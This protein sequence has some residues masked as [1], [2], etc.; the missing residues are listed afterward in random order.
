MSIENVAVVRRGYEALAGGDFGG[1][2]GLLDPEIEW[3]HPE[4]LPYSGTHRGIAGMQEVLRLWGEAYEEMRVVPQEFLDAGDAVVVI[5]RYIVRLHD[6]DELS[7]WFV[8]VFDLAD[9]RIVRFRDYSDK[10]VRLASHK[11]PGGSMMKS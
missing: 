7:T 10:A 1:F 6:G 2:L 5:G 3:T 8:N 4:G 9:G 11:I